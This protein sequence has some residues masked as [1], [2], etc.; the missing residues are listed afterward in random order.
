MR[1][2]GGGGGGGRGRHRR[3]GGG[4]GK[5]RSKEEEE[6]RQMKMLERE[7]KEI[8][9][10]NQRVVEEAPD[11]GD[12]E[13]EKRKFTELALSQYTQQALRA[14]KFKRMT[15]IQRCAIPHALAGRDVL[16]AAKTG[17]GKTLAFMIPSP[18][19]K[20]A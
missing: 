4:R 8:S 16:G 12:T 9:S 13:R 10:L 14:G 6:H 11:V 2:R 20:E 3:D 19:N 1:K 7:S 17:S 18:K 5:R 15:Q